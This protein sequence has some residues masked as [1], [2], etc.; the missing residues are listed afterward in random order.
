MG[1]IFILVNN[2]FNDSF[3]DGI[4][5]SSLEGEERD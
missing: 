4:C 3:R 1:K 2:T 5:H